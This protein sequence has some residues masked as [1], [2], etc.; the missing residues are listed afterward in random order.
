M[1]A[2]F[3]I[4]SFHYVKVT[5]VQASPKVAPILVVAPHSSFFDAIVAI[6]ATYY[7]PPAAVAKA[8]TAMLPFFG[9]MCTIVCI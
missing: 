5:G 9:S 4:G 8:E 7:G 3:F 1:R 2:M 6:V